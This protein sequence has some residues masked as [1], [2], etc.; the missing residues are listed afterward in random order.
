MVNYFFYLVLFPLLLKLQFFTFFHIFSDFCVLIIAILIK[1]LPSSENF[2]F[3]NLF[4]FLVWFFA[5]LKFFVHFTS[6][7]YKILCNISMIFFLW[8]MLYV[9]TL[10]W[11]SIERNFRKI[12]CNYTINSNWPN[13]NT[14]F[15]AKMIFFLVWYAKDR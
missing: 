11:L 12:R 1:I 14:I 7:M 9:F 5:K 10:I 2:F 8:F 15:A 6:F 3:L 4:F 13:K